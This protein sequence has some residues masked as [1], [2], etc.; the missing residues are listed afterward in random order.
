MSLAAPTRQARSTVAARAA[1]VDALNGAGFLA[2]SA[3][4]DSPTPGAAWPQWTS[5]AFDGHLCDPSRFSFSVYLVL[6]AGDSTT[7]VAA[8]DEAVAIA[9]PA[10]AKVAD[11]EAAEPVLITFSDS[12]TMPGIRFRLTTRA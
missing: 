6:T 10:L 11:I 12:T 1:L 4:P 3:A 2:S 7:T 8:G 5:T 9:A